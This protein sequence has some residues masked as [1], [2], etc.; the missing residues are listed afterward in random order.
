MNIALVL[1][2]GTGTRL[3][4]DTPKQYL[5][6]KDKMIISY[7]LETFGKSE[8]IDGVCI[9]A[10]LMWQEELKALIESYNDECL[11]QKT[12]NYI[13][14]KFRG[15]SAPGANRQLYIYNGLTDILKF[16]KEDSAILIHDA[17]RPM[18]SGELI[19]RCFT[20][21]EG[22]DGVMP[23]LPMKDTVY[24]SEDG[25]VVSKLLKRENIFAGQSPELFNLGKYYKACEALL[26][27]RIMTI[28][29]STEPAILAG[30]DIAIVD[31]DEK[32][33]KITTKA[34]LERFERCVTE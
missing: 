22:H 4:A 19:E 13:A 17:A 15:F 7:C 29:G 14:R 31:G 34:D 27:D 3:G 5:K 6:V 32:N 2:G 10:D 28:N 25:K 18:L 23:V 12:G 33:F 24:M 21:Y 30:M 16:A 20:S 9:V 1:A 8:H 11:T 26:P